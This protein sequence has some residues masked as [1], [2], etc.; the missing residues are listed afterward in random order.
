MLPCKWIE[1][2]FSYLSVSSIFW[3]MGDYRACS[4]VMRCCR[5]DGK[6]WHYHH[7]DI[8]ILLYMFICNKTLQIKWHFSLLSIFWYVIDCYTCSHCIGLVQIWWSWCRGQRRQL[9]CKKYPK[10]EWKKLSL[11]RNIWQPVM[12]PYLSMTG[13]LIP[14]C[15]YL[16]HELVCWINAC[17]CLSIYL[18]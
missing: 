3:Y 18:F 14:L 9:F 16:Q 2:F 7:Y 11:T 12:L 5:I 1:F 8:W 15:I 4:S 17:N 10:M 13:D 6:Y